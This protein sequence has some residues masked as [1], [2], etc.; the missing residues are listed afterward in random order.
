MEKETTFQEFIESHLVD[1]KTTRQYLPPTNKKKWLYHDMA[2]N[3]FP[4]IK[5]GF[6]QYVYNSGMPLHDFVNHVR[7]SQIFCINLFFT[8]LQN[9]PEVLIRVLGNS[10]KTKLKSLE[11]FEF[12]FS[13]E[14]NILGEWK[15]DENRPEEYVTATD[16][17]IVA[18]DDSNSSIGFLIEVK[19]TEHDFSNCGGYTSTS[20]YSESRKICEEGKLL[21]SDF[22]SCYLQGANGKSKLK[23][24]YLDFFNQSDFNSS[25]FEGKCPFI[26]NNQCLRNHALLRGLIREKKIEAGYFILVYHDQNRSIENEWFK[27]IEIL[28]DSAIK[29]VQ[30]IPASSFLKESNNICYQNYFNDRYLIYNQ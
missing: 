16:L 3:L 6:L 26:N 12:E 23:R 21:L 10:V 17:F 18:K 14:K 22:Q 13:A 15:S 9:E 20:N 1:F 19:F 8:L 7:S 30:K 29:Q 24:K 11:S 2:D 28:T 25:S 4:P 27:Y 5:H